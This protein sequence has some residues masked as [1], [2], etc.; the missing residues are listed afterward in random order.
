MNI[1]QSF[2]VWTKLLPGN[3]VF[4]GEPIAKNYLKKKKKKNYTLN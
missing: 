4:V 2:L 3:E 1:I